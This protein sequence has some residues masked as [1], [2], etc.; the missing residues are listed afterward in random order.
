[1]L[2]RESICS[3]DWLCLPQRINPLFYTPWISC[4][5]PL[6]SVSRDQPSHPY[7]SGTKIFR[8]LGAIKQKLSLGE[9]RVGEEWLQGEDGNGPAGGGVALPMQL[10]RQF[11][12]LP[13][14]GPAGSLFLS[15]ALSLVMHCHTWLW[16]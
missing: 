7:W 14:A 1:M 4:P 11:G 12:D 2:G 8:W 10:L 6:R 3:F 9:L 13:S 5:C 15:P 16:S